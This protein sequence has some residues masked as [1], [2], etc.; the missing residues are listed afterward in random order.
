V[1][2]ST[3]SSSGSSGVPSVSGHGRTA[4]PAKSTPGLWSRVLGT[5]EFWR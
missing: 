5:L 2:T 3:G 1:S 4:S